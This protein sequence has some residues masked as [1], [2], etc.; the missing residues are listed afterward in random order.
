MSYGYRPG[1]GLTDAEPTTYR[2]T[3]IWF[4]RRRHFLKKRITPCSVRNYIPREIASTFRF[5]LRPLRDLNR[6]LKGKSSRLLVE[7]KCPNNEV[8][9]GFERVK[10]V[11]CNAKQFMDTP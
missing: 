9:C 11:G 8:R 1:T 7:L 3:A 5:S 2:L 4:Y 10:H 6:F